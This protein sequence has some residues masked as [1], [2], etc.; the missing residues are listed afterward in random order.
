MRIRCFVAIWLFISAVVSW[1]F[2]AW[3][4]LR[5]GLPRP[6]VALV[7]MILMATPMEVRTPRMGARII[8]GIIGGGFLLHLLAPSITTIDRPIS[9]E[10]LWTRTG[11]SFGAVTWALAG[12]LLALGGW[13][14]V[15]GL[16]RVRRRFVH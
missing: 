6:F 2:A 12:A 1:C 8:A 15:W 13:L 10:A 14:G 7:V 4:F 9:L 5:D 11:D 16:L 3:L